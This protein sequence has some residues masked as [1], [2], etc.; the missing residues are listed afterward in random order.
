MA[1][2]QREDGSRFDPLAEQKAQ[3]MLQARIRAERDELRVALAAAREREKGLREALAKFGAHRGNCQ[4]Y[5]KHSGKADCT[6]G[7]V[8]ALAREVGG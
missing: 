2:Q 7:L 3:A 8:A 6:C 5:T 1:E 4:L